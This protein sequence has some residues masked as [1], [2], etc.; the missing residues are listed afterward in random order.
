MKKKKN[1]IIYVSNYYMIVKNYWRKSKI[2]KRKNIRLH[3]N[4]RSSYDRRVKYSMAQKSKI[5]M[6]QNLKLLSHHQPTPP[7]L[8]L[9]CSI[10]HSSMYITSYLTSFTHKAHSP[11]LRPATHD[12]LFKKI[13]HRFTWYIGI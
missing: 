13:S 10:I 7:P 5:F 12:Q 3:K 4:L 1:L 11:R 8:K 9:S 6:K 2:M